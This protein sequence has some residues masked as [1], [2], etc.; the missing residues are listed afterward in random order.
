MRLISLALLL[1]LATACGSQQKNKTEKA[2][3]AITLE[4]EPGADAAKLAVAKQI[5]EKR[6]LELNEG[7]PAI[8]VT[9]NKIRL[10]MV[11]EPSQAFIKNILLARGHLEFR[12]TVNQSAVRAYYSDKIQFYSPGYADT[13]PMKDGRIPRIS[14]KP[15]NYALP[16]VVGAIEVGDTA[17]VGNLFRG[18]EKDN[19]WPMGYRIAWSATPDE[20]S[21]GRFALYLIDYSGQARVMDN[22]PLEKAS[23]DIDP[24]VNRP[25]VALAFKPESAKAFEEMTSE[26]R[27]KHIA[28]LVDGKVHSCPKVLDAIT[29]GKASIQGEY[30]TMENARKMA[31]VLHAGELPLQLKLAGIETIGK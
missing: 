15:D 29:G 23:V 8:T 26:N 12:L 17:V 25:V 1:T 7:V 22:P 24:I 10:E 21:L 13:M 4:A 2:N 6:F 11:A 19:A 18:F 3:F 14:I 30:K 20:R 27:G 5:L 16:C 31:A 28:I 9:G